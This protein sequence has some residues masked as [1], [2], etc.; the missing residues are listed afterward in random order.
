VITVSAVETEWR[1]YRTRFLIEARQLTEPLSFI[2]ALG[3]EQK[4]D[5]GDYLVESAGLL[6]IA[7]RAIFEDIYVP[8]EVPLQA[9]AHTRWTH[10]LKPDLPADSA[11]SPSP[12]RR[13][14]LA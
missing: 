7:P 2:D 8:L 11:S 6:R 3:R 10:S 9:E 12:A 14:A 5:V 4:G 1:T 13:I